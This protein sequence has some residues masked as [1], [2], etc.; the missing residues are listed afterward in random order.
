[1][2]AMLTAVLT[3]I[4]IMTVLMVFEPER[5]SGNIGA[6]KRLQLFEVFHHLII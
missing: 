3:M 5:G 1:M 4:A 2:V 6:A